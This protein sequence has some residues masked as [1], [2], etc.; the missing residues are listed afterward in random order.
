LA[1][2]GSAPRDAGTRMLVTRD[3]LA[4]TIGG[5]NLEMQALRQARLA[6]DQP[7]GSWRI[8]DYPL[9]P[10]LQQCCGGRVRLL[11][12]H[13]DAAQ[14]PW[15]SALIEPGRHDFST[16][17]LPN[18]LER[19]LT[20]DPQARPAKAMETAPLSGAVILESS[21][22]ALEPLFMAGAGHVGVAIAKALEGLP[23]ALDWRDVREDMAANSGARLASAEELEEA[24]GA[25]T[26]L[27]LVLTHDHALDYRLT[28][29]A[30]QGKA[31]FVGVI[32]SATKRA[33]FL[34][35]LAKDGLT[36]TRFHCP[37]GLPGIT[38]KEPAVIAVSVAAQ[39]LQLPR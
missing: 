11:I 38:G 34:S 16:H 25:A 10:L 23:F 32:G 12:E 7:K 28:K 39:L 37:I 18:R 8:Q 31:R 24:A 13:L 19:N 2:E 33:R 15:I 14:R 26:G 17:F 20:A 30:L 35:R 6:L 9:G 4:G 27:V 3:D 5:G 36:E 1:V 29:A 21:G 22:M